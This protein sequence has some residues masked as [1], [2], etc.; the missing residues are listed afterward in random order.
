[1]VIVIKNCR[2]ADKDH[3][4]YMSQYAH[5]FHKGDNVIC[6]ARA[7]WKLPIGHQMGLIAHEIGHILAGEREHREYK[8][9]EAANRYFGID[10]KY[11]DSEYGY[12]LQYLNKR[13]IEKV[14]KVLA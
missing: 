10:I 9:D 11:K 7:F 2:E 4:E 13:D 6:V 3:K 5:T 12:F 8:A 1:M 14:A